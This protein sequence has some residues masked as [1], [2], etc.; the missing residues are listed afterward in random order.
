[1]CDPADGIATMI[2]SISLTYGQNGQAIF[3]KTFPLVNGKLDCANVGYLDKQGADDLGV[4]ALSNTTF[5]VS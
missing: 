2:G 3:S 1:M 5:H 4:C